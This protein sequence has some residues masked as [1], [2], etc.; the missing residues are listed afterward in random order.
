MIPLTDNFVTRYSCEN[1]ILRIG[2]KMVKKLFLVLTAAML[3]CAYPV[4]AQQ[5]KKFPRL[6]FLGGG[7][8]STSAATVEAFR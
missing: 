6:G 4:D 3:A 1:K 5:T 7:S 8:A 2:G